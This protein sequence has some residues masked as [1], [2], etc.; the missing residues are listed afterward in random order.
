MKHLRVSPPP[1]SENAIAR[2]E[3]AKA[4]AYSLA[5][6]DSELFEPK[7]I[8]WVDRPSEMAS[9]VLEGCSWQEGWHDY[10]VSHGGRLEIS[11]G[12]ESSFIFAKSSP[13]DSYEHFG[14]GPFINL[15]DTQGNEVIC[16]RSGDACVSLDE[17]TSK[18]T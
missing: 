15:R 14:H 7:L 10:G 11:V 5:E 16:R 13:F 8:A 6:S 1:T 2:F 9:P 3:A 18:L 17:W 4:L 12:Y